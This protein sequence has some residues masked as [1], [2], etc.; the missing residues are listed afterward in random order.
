MTPE[1]PRPN[2]APRRLPVLPPGAVPR[3]RHLFRAG[4]P[5]PRCYRPHRPAELP[6]GR[7]RRALPPFP[8]PARDRG[9]RPGRSLMAAGTGEGGTA[10]RAELPLLRALVGMESPLHEDGLRPDSDLPALARDDGSARDSD[11]AAGEEA[12]GALLLRPVA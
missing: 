2:E 5:G 10:P 1:A 8:Q 12:L 4:P 3:E 9:G 6:A 11:E 7:G